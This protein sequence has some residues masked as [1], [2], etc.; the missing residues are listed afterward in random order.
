[1]LHL[2]IG[3]NLIAGSKTSGTTSSHVFRV[4]E[5]ETTPMLWLEASYRATVS[6]N[7]DIASHISEESNHSQLT[8]IPSLDV[9]HQHVEYFKH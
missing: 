2:E 3:G 1:M 9:F 6:P 4:W 5:Q 8:N 7:K